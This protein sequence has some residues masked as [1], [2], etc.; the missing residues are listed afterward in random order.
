MLSNVGTPALEH[1][2]LVA[3]RAA[4][5]VAEI[6]V[7]GIRDA[8]VPDPLPGIRV[9]RHRT[10]GG[11]GQGEHGEHLH[12]DPVSA[13]MHP[14]RDGRRRDAL[15]PDDDELVLEVSVYRAP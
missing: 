3:P 15:P 12:A 7:R 13:A 5:E 9:C 14:I 6:R 11:E 8:T 1:P 2:H 4:G 10:D